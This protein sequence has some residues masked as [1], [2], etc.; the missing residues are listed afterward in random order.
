MAEQRAPQVDSLRREVVRTSDEVAAMLRLHALGWGARRI[1]AELG[2]SR[3]TVKRYVGLGGWAPLRMARR[4]R[5]LD[6]LGG[7]LA[8]RFRRHR[9]NADVVRQELLAE[10]G[11]AVSLRTVERAVTH[12]RRE[13]AA[14]ARATVRFETPPGRQM[15]ID[16][17]GASVVIGGEVVRVFLFVATLGH[18]RRTFVRAFRHER[19][20]AWLDG[21]ESAFRHFGG[22]P[23]EILLDNARALV[24]HHDARTRE[25]VF[26][27]RLHAFARYWRVRPV[28]CAPYRARTKGKDERGVGY[29]K[30]NALA[31]RG[32]ASWAALEA[33]LAWWMR[34]VA[35]RRIHGTTGEPPITRFARDEA[36][37]LR[38]ID[39]R[40][41]FRQWRELSRRVHSDCAIEVDTNA[42]S[43]PWRLIGERV[44]V[45]VVDGWVRIFH[46]GH[47]VAAHP[48][49][50]GRHQRFVEPAHFQGVPGFRRLASEAGP[51]PA[52]L[53]G[54]EPEFLRPLAEYEH[55]I[56]GGW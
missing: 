5:A 52:L 3:N 45:T 7:W 55:A 40:P 31:G 54:T 25:V 29:V 24:T 48:E 51:A 19:Q 32:F 39:G 16:F 56:G 14:E 11:I 12:L 6:E 26:N 2:C 8:E 13:L 46:V 35:D 17:G 4:P 50:A 41:P 30:G 10:H 37:A 22:L 27:E 36:A 18:S 44:Q 43:V 42:Y 28:A 53:P 47:E 21:I 23:A 49:A 1:A 38:P 9:G 20:T 34:E 15:Q 33:H